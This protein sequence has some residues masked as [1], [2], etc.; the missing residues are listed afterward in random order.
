MSLDVTPFRTVYI[1]VDSALSV[2]VTHVIND[3]YYPRDT[4]GDYILKVGQMREL[5]L[6]VS[7]ENRGEEAHEATLYVD[8]PESLSYT[9]VTTTQVSPCPT[10]GSPPH[11]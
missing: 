9:G 7:V 11:R 4:S 8:L 10:P 6:E 3:I 2:A 5:K 1:T